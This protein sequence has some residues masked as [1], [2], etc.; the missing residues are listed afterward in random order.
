MKYIF[1]SEFWAKQSQIIS[2][3][4]I[5]FSFAKLPEKQTSLL[6]GNN[7]HFHSVKVITLRPWVLLVVMML[8]D[9]GSNP[10]SAMK[11]SHSYLMLTNIKGFCK[12]KRT[13]GRTAY[14]TLS[15][16]EKEWDKMVR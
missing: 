15:F 10:H 1:H 8:G 13:E 9:T 14:I 2:I 3:L 7:A 11:F 12:N 6:T 5:Q 16:L 4:P